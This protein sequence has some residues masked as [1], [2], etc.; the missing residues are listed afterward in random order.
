MSVYGDSFVYSNEVDDESAWPN[1]LARKVGR[2]I[3]NFGIGSYSTAQ[4][5]LRYQQ[6]SRDA[7]RIVVLGFLSENIK[8]NVNQFR[9]LLFPDNP[10]RFSP[11]FVLDD[12]GEIRLIPLPTLTEGQFHSVI[13][14]PERYLKDEVFAPGGMAG[15]QAF[16][17][18]YTWTLG[19]VLLRNYSIAS[20]LRGEPGGY[21]VFYQPQHPSH[22]FEIT[23]GIM[24]RFVS[25]ARAQGRIPYVLVI[26][27]ATDLVYHQKT[28]RWVYQSL[29]DTL[30]ARQLPYWHVGDDLL[31]RMGTRSVKD[32]YV[33]GNLGAHPNA[34]G[35]RIMAEVVY[36]RMRR[37]R[38]VDAPQ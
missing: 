4:A 13:E 5:Y 14:H 27:K 35:N 37:S 30:G 33:N 3:N 23:I 10:A 7:A 15:V 28:G 9:T 8:R 32:F 2:R 16:N 31:L 20:A 6:N 29:L 38:I 19:K 36:D 26:P 24:D 34:E 1:L 21:T 12:Q 25:E 11:R 17:F 22:A 18:P